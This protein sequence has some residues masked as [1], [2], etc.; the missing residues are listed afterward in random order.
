MEWQEPLVRIPNAGAASAGLNGAFTNARRLNLTGYG[1][2]QLV[3][4]RIDN[5]V[6]DPCAD[7]A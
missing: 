7:S 6:G 3:R 4:S 2:L 1:Q 5:V